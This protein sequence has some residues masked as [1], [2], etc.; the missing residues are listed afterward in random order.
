MYVKRRLNIYL[1]CTTY[2]LVYKTFMKYDISFENNIC[3]H[4]TE[5]NN[6]HQ[7]LHMYSHTIAKVNDYE[8][9]EMARNIFVFI[10]STEISTLFLQFATLKIHSKFTVFNEWTFFTKWK[11]ITNTPDHINYYPEISRI[12][13]QNNYDN[14]LRNS[15]W[16]VRYLNQS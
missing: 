9:W 13:I 15:Q 1:N 8:N 6:K 2:L 10:F 14:L 5:G 7:F 3:N 16:S 11:L 12:Q 4:T